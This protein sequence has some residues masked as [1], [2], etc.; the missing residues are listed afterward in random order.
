MTSCTS[1]LLPDPLTPVTHVTMPSGISTSM[2]FRLCSDAPRTRSF[3]FVGFRRADG[4]GIASSSRRYFAVSE[5]GSWSSSAS[6]PLKITRPP[7][8]PAPSP[9]STIVSATRIMSASCSTTSTVLP[10]SRSCR[11]IA[12]SRSL[13]RECS[14]IEGSSRTY[15]VSTSAEPSDVA[16]LMRCDS[17]PESVED[18]R[19]SVRYSRPTSRRNPRRLRISRRTLSAIAASFS[20]SSSVAKKP[21]ASRTVRADTASI[22]RPPTWTSRASRRRRAPPHSGQVRYPR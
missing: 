17:P 13:S 1:V 14:P 21:S 6:V 22:V 19:S 16:R 3:W 11:R 10:W 4:T 9:M 20:V 18:S 12:I 5:R 7:C 8:S 15:R 2:A